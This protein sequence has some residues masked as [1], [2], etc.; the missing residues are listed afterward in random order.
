MNAQLFYNSNQTWKEQANISRYAVS[1][2]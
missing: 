1:V 2:S